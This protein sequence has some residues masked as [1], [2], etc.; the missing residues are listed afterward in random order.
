MTADRRLA[1]YGSLAPGQSNH[2]QLAGLRGDWSTG[3][4]RGWRVESGWGAAQGY[5]GLRPDPAGPAVAV[6]VFS[7]DDLAA[8]WARLDAFEGAE[9]E[10]LVV[11]VEAPG[12]MT[13]AWLYA[14]RLEPGVA[15]PLASPPRPAP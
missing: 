10:R 13:D 3:T 14:L 5:P 8:H 12:G 4:V 7:S 6:Q 9:Y 15:S 2:H 11:P 1:V